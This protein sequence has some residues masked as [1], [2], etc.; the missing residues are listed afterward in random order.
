MPQR[1]QVKIGVWIVPGALGGEARGVIWIGT[2]IGTVGRHGTVGGSP[3][4]LAWEEMKKHL[5]RSSRNFDQTDTM[6]EMIFF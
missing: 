1:V 5:E 4:A 2:A 3:P 6:E